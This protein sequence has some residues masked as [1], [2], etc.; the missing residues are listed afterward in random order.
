MS[1]RS[2]ASIISPGVIIGFFIQSKKSYNL[3]VDKSGW[4]RMRQIFELTD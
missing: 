3:Y 1:T 2:L 4:A